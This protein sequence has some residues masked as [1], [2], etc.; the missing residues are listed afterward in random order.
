MKDPEFAMLVAKVAIGMTFSE[1]PWSSTK[2]MLLGVVGS[3]ITVKGL[4]DG[5]FC[6]AATSASVAISH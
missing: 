2:E 6:E 1:G 5:T 4:H 3:H